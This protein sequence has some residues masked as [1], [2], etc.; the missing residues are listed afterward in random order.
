GHRFVAQLRAAL[1]VRLRCAQGLPQV[2]GRVYASE[3]DVWMQDE[4]SQELR[5]DEPRRPV[6]RGFE[7]LHARQCSAIVVAPLVT[8]LGDDSG[9]VKGVRWRGG[10]R[11]RCD[12]G[13][14]LASRSARSGPDSRW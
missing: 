3:G 8:L 11:R 1:E 6:D 4:T 9:R 13:R 2:V 12:S 5:A 14:G 7:S 10:L